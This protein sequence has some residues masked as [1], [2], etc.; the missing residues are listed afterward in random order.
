MEAGVH[1]R[2]LSLAPQTYNLTVGTSGSYY[3]AAYGID[4]SGIN[5]MLDGL[6]APLLLRT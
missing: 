6:P 2:V 1:P 5:A 3:E 4:V